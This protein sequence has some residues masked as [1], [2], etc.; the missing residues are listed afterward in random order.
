M[1]HIQH[2]LH[3][4]ITPINIIFM[5]LLHFSSVI[6]LVIF[7]KSSFLKIKC[8]NQPAS[9]FPSCTTYPKATK[10]QPLISV[11]WQC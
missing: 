8:H 1:D 2:E 5:D 9:E 6:S 4:R 10:V 11:A 3:A 7:H